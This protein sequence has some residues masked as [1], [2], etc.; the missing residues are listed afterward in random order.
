LSRY[1]TLDFTSQFMETVSRKDFGPRERRLFLKALE[2][3]DADERHPSLRLR[4]LGG[5]LAGELSVSAS[6]SLRITF[7]RLAGGR[8]L[9]LRCSRHYDR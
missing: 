6:D 2:L 5:G 1:E 3:L 9:L 4:G 8:K 7:E